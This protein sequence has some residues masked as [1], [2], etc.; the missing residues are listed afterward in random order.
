M[1]ARHTRD[2]VA[3]ISDR[4]S[5]YLCPRLANLSAQLADLSAQVVYVGAN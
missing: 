5:P 1:I 2:E 4:Q 3:K